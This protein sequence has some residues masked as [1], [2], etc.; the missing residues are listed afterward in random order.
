VAE[1]IPE[2]RKD[3]RGHMVTRWVRKDAPGAA[4]KKALPKV[5]AS[6]SQESKLETRR[7]RTINRMTKLLLL[8][9]YS[10]DLEVMREEL[11]EF[12][13]KYKDR[14]SF[15]VIDAALKADPQ[16]VTSVENIISD[17]PEDKAREI[18]H[19]RDH[20]DPD[21]REDERDALVA[22][23]RDYPVFDGVEDFTVLKG[24]E[25]DTAVNLLRVGSA[26]L[27]LDPD[28]KTQK[29]GFRWHLED[30]A[31]VDAVLSHPDRI[32]EMTAFMEERHVFDG[33]AITDYLNEHSALNKGVL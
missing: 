3:K 2:V 16:S 12:L 31:L 32:D 29:G 20:I 19:F 15:E 5:A 9:G 6:P 1:L 7:N 17:Y 26:V 27:A 11:H 10:Y 30:T 14:R 22:G 28:V 23:L 24:A 21:L 4:A 13:D 33:K 18:I 25:H 8:H